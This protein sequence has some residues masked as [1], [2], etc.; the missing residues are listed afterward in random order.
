MR[1]ARW[2]KCNEKLLLGP[3]VKRPALSGQELQ[4]PRDFQILWV[5]GGGM[6][7]KQTCCPVTEIG[8]CTSPSKR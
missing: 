7:N 8:K 5:G 4:K 3:N 1:S 6:N 2:N